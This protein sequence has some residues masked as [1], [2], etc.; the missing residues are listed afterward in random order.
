MSNYQNAVFP[1][2]QSLKELLLNLILLFQAFTR[3]FT[4]YLKH[5]AHLRGAKIYT[6]FFLTMKYYKKK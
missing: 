6:F 4:S 3:L 5:S 1:F 2:T